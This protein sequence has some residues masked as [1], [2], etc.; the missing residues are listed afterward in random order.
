MRASIKEI[1]A[2]EYVNLEFV[3]TATNI[4]KINSEMSFGVSVNHSAI[5]R[6]QQRIILSVGRSSQERFDLIPAVAT[7][8][9]A[10]SRLRL[11]LV[12][13]R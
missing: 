3:P 12:R 8:I 13:D 2:R 6:S 4:E 10:Q 1:T 9:L 5:S 11:Y 7:E